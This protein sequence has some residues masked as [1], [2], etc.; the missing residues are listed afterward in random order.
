MFSDKIAGVHPTPYNSSLTDPMEAKAAAISI[1]ED[2]YSM[3]IHWNFAPV[4]DVSKVNEAIGKRSF[5]DDPEEVSRLSWAFAKESKSWE[6]RLQLS[7]FQAMEPLP[8]IHIKGWQLSM[9][10]LKNFFLFGF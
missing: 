3:G 10:R 4:C 8:E 1:S 9:V 7:T 6:S 2:L 5:S